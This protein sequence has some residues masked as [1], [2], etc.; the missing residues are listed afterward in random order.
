[1]ISGF[2]YVHHLHRTGDW[3]LVLALVVLL[4]AMTLVA[5]VRILR[6]PSRKLDLMVL[7]GAIVVA[8]IWVAQAVVPEGAVLISFN[9]AHGLTESDLLVFPLIAAG[10]WLFVRV[11]RSR[12]DRQSDDVDA[13]R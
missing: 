8:V 7:L 12:E 10:C 3:R 1:V 4:V 11:I 5:Y 2:A 6:P 9:R 13:L